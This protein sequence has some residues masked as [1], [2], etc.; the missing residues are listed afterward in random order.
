MYTNVDE[1]SDLFGI[2]LVSKIRHV[3][4]QKLGQLNIGSNKKRLFKLY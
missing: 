3:K 2:I 1:D 4:R